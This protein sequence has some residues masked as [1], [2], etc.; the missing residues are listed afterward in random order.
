M[1]ET[2]RI[3]HLRYT[4]R[5]EYDTEILVHTASG[6]VCTLQIE[7]RKTKDNELV[8]FADTEGWVSIHVRPTGNPD[9]I[10]SLILE[11]TAGGNTVKKVIELRTHTN[12][13]DEFPFPP[14]DIGES[15]IKG[16]LILPALTDGEIV[17][18]TNEELLARGYPMRPNPKEVTDAYEIWKEIV[19]A[20]IT[21]VPPHTVAHPYLRCGPTYQT[22]WSGY[23]L[24]GTEGTDTYDWVSGFWNV[25]FVAPRYILPG[26]VANPDYSALWVG[27]DNGAPDIVQAGTIHSAIHADSLRVSAYA[28]WTEFYPS[29]GTVQVITGFRVNPGN[30]IYVQVWIG[31]LFPV[32]VSPLHSTNSNPT[33]P[34]IHGKYCFFHV[35]NATTGKSALASHFHGGVTVTG[36]EA[37]WIMELPT[38]V[39]GPNSS[40]LPELSD[41]GKCKISG[42]CAKNAISGSFVNYGQARNSEIWMESPNRILSQ[43]ESISNSEIEFIWRAFW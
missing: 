12:A 23:E 36:T 31:D 2:K 29:Q 15:V 32:P 42:A 5:P 28:A 20:P 21:V 3:P 13:T 8:V 1:H 43:V 34:G 4:I 22:T 40:Y 38:I 33:P 30:K 18:L 17:K 10:N 24:L 37:E 19:S 7:G 16:S 25:P 26:Q 9:D 14:H 11:Y 35:F 6:A 27:L 41:Y 39:T